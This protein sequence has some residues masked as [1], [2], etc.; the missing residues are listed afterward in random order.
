MYRL[1]A[2]VLKTLFCKGEVSAETLAEMSL[3]RIAHHDGNVGAFLKVLSERVMQKA[4]ALDDKRKA[5]KP[6]GK[7]AGVPIAIKDNIH[8]FGEMTTCGS[9]FLE[10]YRI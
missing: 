7:L 9:K 4:K 8:I 6:L 5:G 2:H 1:P 10:N 3:K